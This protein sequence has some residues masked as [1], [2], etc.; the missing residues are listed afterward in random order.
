MKST[1]MRATAITLTTIGLI[2][3]IILLEPP[4]LANS[5]YPFHMP[6]INLNESSLP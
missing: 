4:A 6:Q 1:R 2:A 5:D 3:A